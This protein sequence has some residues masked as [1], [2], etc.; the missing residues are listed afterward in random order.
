MRFKYLI[1]LLFAALLCLSATGCSDEDIALSGNLVEIEKEPGD[2]FAVIHVLDYGEM[3]FK[4]FP[5]IAPVAVEKFVARAE[6]EYGYYEYRNF[7]RVVEDFLIQGGSLLGDGSD[8]A[9]QASEYF[10]IESSPY[11]RNFYGALCM[12]PD[13]EGRNYAQISIINNKEPQDIDAAIAELEEKLNDTTKV[14]KK[15]AKERY[16]AYLKT[17]KDIPEN[18]KEMY[19]SKGGVYYLDGEQTVFGQLIDGFDV[20]EAISAV[21]VA[22][23]NAIDDA[24]EIKS[25]PISEIVITKVEIIRI[26]LPEPTTTTEET[27]TKKTKKTTTAETTE[28]VVIGETTEIT[29]SAEESDVPETAGEN[30]GEET[31]PDEAE[32]AGEALPEDGGEEALEAE[33]ADDEALLEE[34]AEGD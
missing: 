9:V 25:K 22:A 12:A 21:E 2:I 4:L 8:G 15:E 6:Q 29:V 1:S 13:S 7:H 19:L 5:E 26:P 14:M 31:A 17:L 32:S 28:V 24:D 27:T 16:T 11:A 10:E 18:V 20:L 23:G 3:T 34:T 33:T 30:P